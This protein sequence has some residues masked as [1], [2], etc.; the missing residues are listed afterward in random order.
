M[1]WPKE[2][3]GIECAPLDHE[4]ARERKQ[5]NLVRGAKRH[6]R[7]LRGPAGHRAP[8]GPGKAKAPGVSRS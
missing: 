7:E 2:E 8:R 5:V 3:N 1:L 6:D 4:Y